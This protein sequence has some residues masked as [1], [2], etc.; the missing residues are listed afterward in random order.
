MMKANAHDINNRQI[1]LDVSI[2][3][4][5]LSPTYDMSKDRKYIVT[6][7]YRMSPSFI[8]FTRR[9]KYDSVCYPPKPRT[10]PTILI[11]PKLL[12]NFVR[13]LKSR[14]VVFS[15]ICRLERC[16]GRV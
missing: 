3:W 6:E 7:K 14:K 15:K 12:V 1:E 2:K 11:T 16:Q 5:H 13:R 9:N 8:I 10:Y 4:T